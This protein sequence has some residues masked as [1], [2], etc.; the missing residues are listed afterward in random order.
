MVNLWRS[1]FFSKCPRFNLSLKNAAKNSEK[2]FSF[3]DNCIWTGTDNFSLLRT[4][5]SSSAVSV[6]TSSPK[7]WHVNKRNFLILNCLERDQKIWWNCCDADFNSIMARWPCCLLLVPLKRHFLHICLTS[8]LESVISEIQNLWGSSFLL[9]C[10]KFKLDFK[11]EAKKWK[12]VLC[13][14]DNCI[15]IG[16]VNCPC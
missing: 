2:V 8:L 5:Y 9:K 16:I 4:G 14:W 13:F 3:W 6:L 1:Y 7:I 11:N 10:L 12:K 15:L